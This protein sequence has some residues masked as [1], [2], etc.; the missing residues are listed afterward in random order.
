MELFPYQ[1]FGA[2]WLV[3]KNVALLADEMGLGKSAQVV[4]AAN[5]S[6][7]KRILILCPAIARFN[8]ANEFELFWPDAPHNITIV[9]EHALKIIDHPQH[10]VIASYD[11]MEKILKDCPWT[12]DLIVPDERHFLKSVDAK[13][14]SL[15]YG[16]KGLVRRTKRVWELSGTPVPNNASELWTMLYT[17]GLTSL[18]FDDFVKRYCTT[19]PNPHSRKPGA[20]IITGTN[21]AMA[22]ELRG[23][24]SKIM[25]RRMKSEVLKDLPPLT[26]SRFTVEAGYVDMEMG[27]MD[28]Y[29]P[30]DE[31][32][33]LLEKLKKEEQ[34]LRVIVETIK[35]N[36]EVSMRETGVAA[37]ESLAF[38]ARSISS[39]RRFHGLQKVEKTFELVKEELEKGKYNKLVIFGVHVA[40]I[41]ALRDKFSRARVK[42]HT[43]YGGTPIHKREKF[44]K[45]FR[46]KSECKILILNI[47]ACGTAINLT[48]CHNVLFVEQS[49][50]PGDNAQAAMRCHRL[51]QTEPVTVRAV[52]LNND[53]E[54]RITTILLNKTQSIAKLLAATCPVSK[55]KLEEKITTPQFET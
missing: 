48:N 25:L 31:S 53:L 21:N 10:I 2:E 6:H 26:F 5:Q 49:F 12:W 1:K 41:E 19:R 34:A 39:L 52:M 55:P 36:D 44:L 42:C 51:G 8:W 30:T 46:E 18:S 3:S 14:T 15:F 24:L 43:I 7:L 37:P 50:V 32:L 11:F 17:Y 45:N 28:Y 23:I 4:T 16:T 35:V 47:Q 40:V 54:K 22:S 27:F 20:V 38:V 29:Y 13:R 9:T 33:E